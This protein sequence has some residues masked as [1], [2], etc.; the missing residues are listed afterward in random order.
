MLGA[1]WLPFVVGVANNPEAIPPV[2]GANGGSWDAMPFRIVPERGQVSE[3][4]SKPPKKECCDVFHDDEAGS[5]L[6]NKSG[7]IAP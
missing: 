5:Y 1:S 6:A 7:V 2:R 3:N 4:V